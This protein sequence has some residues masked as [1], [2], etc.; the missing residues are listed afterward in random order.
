MKV[1]SILLILYSNN[2]NAII[3][4]HEEQDFYNL[5]PKRNIYLENVQ[6]II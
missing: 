1:G 6:L 2:H 5:L 4:H 3:L